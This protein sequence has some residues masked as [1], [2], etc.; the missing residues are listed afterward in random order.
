LD[1]RILNADAFLVYRGFDIGTAKP[2]DRRRYALIDIREPT[3]SFGLGEWLRLALGELESLYSE[4][5]SA[6]VAGGT[7]LY[8]RALFE[9]YADVAAPPDPA[10]RARLAARERSEGLAALVNE[11]HRRAPA[12]ASRVDPCN[13][14]RVRRA[15]ERLD[16]ME[17]PMRLQ[18]PA[19]KRL[20]L[21]LL[22]DVD[23]LSRRIADRVDEM[24]HNG[25]VREV[26]N[27]LER[28]VPDSA[29]AMRAIG[30]R[31]IRMHLRG[32]MSLSEAVERVI[33]DTRRYA[34]RQRTW[35]RTEPGLT[36]FS[37]YSSVEEAYCMA[38]AVTCALA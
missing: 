7:G 18:L 29:P 10:L 9:G 22:P 28:G 16:T 23:W 25:W 37:G 21:G 30:Y 34:K 26:K 3:D 12:V 27:L 8:V 11:L 31:A 15:L 20:K 6:I 4:R 14:V 33:A 38:V 13:P 1:A 24:V 17:E 5:R 19:F 32:E 36:T 35:M 2:V